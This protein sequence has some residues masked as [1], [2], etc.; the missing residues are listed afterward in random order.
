[1]SKTKPEDAKPAPK[2]FYF[3]VIDTLCVD[4]R[5]YLWSV[6]TLIAAGAT[7]LLVMDQAFKEEALTLLALCG[8]MLAI[9]SFVQKY[10]EKE[11]AR[12][13]RRWTQLKKDEKEKDS[14]I[15]GFRERNERL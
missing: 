6:I 7:Y 12:D 8:T 4:Y 9:M 2:G 10:R 1:M 5:Y 3:G 15:K 11:I 14:F 13:I